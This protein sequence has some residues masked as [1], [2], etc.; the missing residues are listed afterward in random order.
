[1][2]FDGRENLKGALPVACFERLEDG[3]ERRALD[4]R[5]FIGLEGIAEQSLNAQLARSAQGAGGHVGRCD[6]RRGER[7]QG[8]QD[9]LKHRLHFPIMP[10]IS[11]FAQDTY[12][13]KRSRK[14]LIRQLFLRRRWE[15]LPLGLTLWGCYGKKKRPR[16]R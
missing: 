14:P 15:N 16:F 4:G 10:M 9:P 6:R 7:E 11:S 13:S 5:T 8:C 3:S 2:R 1:M 12:G